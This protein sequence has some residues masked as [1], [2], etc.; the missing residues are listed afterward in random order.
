MERSAEILVS[1]RNIFQD[2]LD[3]C[4]DVSIPRQLKGVFTSPVAEVTSQDDL[5]Y[6]YGAPLR[7][8]NSICMEFQHIL[9]VEELR[10]KFPLQID[11]ITAVAA[12]Q[13]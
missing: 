3:T 4:M 6:P 2:I 1:L 13:S 7:K 10:S 8:N 5:G 9:G 12:S 11:Q